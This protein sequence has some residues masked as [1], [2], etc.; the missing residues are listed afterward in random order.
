MIIGG[1]EV[2]LGVPDFFETGVSTEEGPTSFAPDKFTPQILQ[3]GALSSTSTAQTGHF[4]IYIHL[5]DWLKA[6]DYGK[7]S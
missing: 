3:K 5:D 1:V 6:F 2:G 4:F 7:H